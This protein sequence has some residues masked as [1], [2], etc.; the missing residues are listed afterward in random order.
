M[1]ADRK[2]SNSTWYHILSHNVTVVTGSLTTFHRLPIQAPLPAA[3]N[4][5]RGFVI[6]RSR[7]RLNHAWFNFYI[8]VICRPPKT[9]EL[10]S[11]RCQ[12]LHEL[13][14]RDDTNKR[15]SS[16]PPAK[17]CRSSLSKWYTYIYLIWDQL[18]WYLI[19]CQNGHLKLFWI[20]LIL[21]MFFRTIQKKRSLDGKRSRCLSTD[22]V[23]RQIE[24][25]YLY[26]IYNCKLIH[27]PPRFD[28][29]LD[30]GEWVQG[31]AC[32]LPPCH[33]TG[34]CPS[35]HS[36]SSMC[37]PG[38][39]DRNMTLRQR[40]QKKSRHFGSVHVCPHHSWKPAILGK[41]LRTDLTEFNEELIKELLSTALRFWHLNLM[42]TS[43]NPRFLR[44]KNIKKMG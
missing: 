8:S 5:T 26:I 36:A 25:R 44:S 24:K 28:F 6:C 43:H 39:T 16:V 32:R 7:P 22:R 23:L 17:R 11:T 27:V 35:K 15:T 40:Q 2:A 42:L 18:L 4:P 3:Q 13:S 9:S 41:I 30:S 21:Q 1:S 29:S 10:A 12:R 31:W 19:C 33:Q 37:T 14:I 34:S 20:V 38:Y